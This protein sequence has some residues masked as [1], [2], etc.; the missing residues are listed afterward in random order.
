MELHEFASDNEI[1]ERNARIVPVLITKLKALQMIGEVAREEQLRRP[2]ALFSKSP[3]KRRI[4][5]DED[6]LDK[7]AHNGHPENGLQQ[8]EIVR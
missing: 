7:Q 5:R 1:R 8:D 6:W 3:Q 4:S 2:F